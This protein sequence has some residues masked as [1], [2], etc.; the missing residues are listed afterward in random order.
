MI[1]VKDGSASFPDSVDAAIIGAGIAGS[2][3]AKALADRGRKVLL[4]DRKTF[5]PAQGMRGNFC[6]RSRSA[7]SPSS[8]SQRRSGRSVRP[9]SGRRESMPS[10]ARLCACRCPVQA[11]GL[12]RHALDATLHRE[13]EL[14]GAAIATGAAVAAMRRDADGYALDLAQGGR[15]RIVR[16]RAVI[17]AWGGNGRV[18][19]ITGRQR[20]SKPALSPYLGVKMHFAGM[21]AAEEVELYF[22]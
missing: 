13:A 12:S 10:A 3:L 9:R 6:R 17:G 8:A 4:I 21:E 20:T 15:S 14:A 2:G 19:D 18:P 5:P 22:F 16:A 11:G 1:A 7:C